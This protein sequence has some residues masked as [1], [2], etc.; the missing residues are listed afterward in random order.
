MTIKLISTRYTNELLLHLLPF[1]TGYLLRTPKKDEHLSAEDKLR[2]CEYSVQLALMLRGIDF[3]MH[4]H[5]AM[6]APE[7]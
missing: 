7:N 5:H 3:S 4:P 1:E 2:P 6:H